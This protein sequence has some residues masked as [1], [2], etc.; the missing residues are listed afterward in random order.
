MLTTYKAIL[1]GRRLQW[2]DDAPLLTAHGRDI[3]VLV[4]MLFE[5]STVPHPS[6][7]QQR[8]RELAAVSPEAAVS[9]AARESRVSCVCDSTA[10]E[11]GRVRG[12]AGAEQEVHFDQAQRLD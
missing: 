12:R 1:H 11:L 7:P 9:R 3:E 6:N 8:R 5:H 2:S 4:T 10:H